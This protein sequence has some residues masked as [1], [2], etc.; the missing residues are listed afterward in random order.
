MADITGQHQMTDTFLSPRDTANRLSVSKS[1]LYL[2]VQ[3]GFLPPPVNLPVRRVCW[4]QSEID[5]MQDA[6][7]AGQSHEQLRELAASLTAK[8]GES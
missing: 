6:L 4:R 7:V 5:A 3:K 1:T 8:R 2:L